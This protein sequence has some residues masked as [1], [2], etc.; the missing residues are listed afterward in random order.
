MKKLV[1]L[2]ENTGYFL[3]IDSKRLMREATELKNYI[4]S[5]KFEKIGQEEL[6]NL[7]DLCN[8]AASGNIT[9]PLDRSEIPLRYQRREGILPDDFDELLSRFSLTATGTP[10][11]VCKQTWVEGQLFAEVEFE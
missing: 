1:P 11:E 8:K 5:R 10:T 4:E 2:D 9:T 7:I 6:N 3:E